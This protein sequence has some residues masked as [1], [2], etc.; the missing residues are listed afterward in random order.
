MKR[1]ILALT[2]LLVS[3]LQACGGSSSN[4]SLETRLNAA[5]EDVMV[6]D[7][8]MSSLQLP[9]VAVDYFQPENDH[10]LLPHG[11]ANIEKRQGFS[12]SSLFH[13]GSI[14]KTFTAAWIMQL[15]QE[16]VL[17]ID[18]TI[19]KFLSFPNGERITLRQLL[20]H[21]SGIENFTEI[22]GIYAL[23]QANPFPTADDIFAFY[24]QYGKQV[25]APG[26]RYQ[27][28][29]TNYY[30]LGRIAELASGETWAIAMHK[31][32]IDPYALTN[33][34]VYGYDTISENVTPYTVCADSTCSS[35][36]NT[37]TGSES[38]FRL[39]W[40]AGSIV[41]TA[42]D[43]SRWMYLLVAGDVLDEAHRIEMQTPTPQSEEYVRAH[44]E[45][46]PMTGVGLCLWHYYSPGVGEGWGHEGE[47][48]GF[49]NLSA[50][51]SDSNFSLTLLVNVGECYVARGYKRLL[52]A[53][54]EP[55][56]VSTGN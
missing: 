20:S 24:R 16:G 31:R 21:T 42:E 7:S 25:F 2:L 52:E 4:S 43:I 11:Y 13:V 36:A 5:I 54:P 35:Y 23:L 51:F 17:S 56:S 26:A 41:S 39:G 28:S 49:S 33:T 3:C 55:A 38:E 15:D 30:L 8:A 37:P 1:L 47:I 14:T 50:Y 53:I 44:P 12:K 10:M 46:A 32:F 9:G 45:T 27:Y 22:S 19:S 34:Y 6:K 40:A 29:N 18:D 48:S